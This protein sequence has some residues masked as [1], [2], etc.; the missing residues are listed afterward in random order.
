MFQLFYLHV[1]SQR[2]AASDFHRLHPIHLH[3]TKSC[4]KFQQRDSI[5]DRLCS[6]PPSCWI[7]KQIWVT[8]LAQFAVSLRQSLHWLSSEIVVSKSSIHCILNNLKWHPYRQ[9]L[10]YKLIKDCP[11][12]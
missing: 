8:V 10:P 7:G 5:A 6:G 4:I 9:Q 3:F 2:K 12:R 1:G 11:D